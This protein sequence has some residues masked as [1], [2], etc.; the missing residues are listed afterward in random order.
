[1]QGIKIKHTNKNQ[2]KP[3]QEPLKK[4][5]GPKHGSYTKL[6]EFSEIKALDS[7]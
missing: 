3:S 2:N 4:V 1:M 5:A 7:F 6:N